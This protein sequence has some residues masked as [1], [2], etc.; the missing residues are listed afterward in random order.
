MLKIIVTLFGIEV[1]YS[2]KT[3]MSKF[4]REGCD[5]VLWSAL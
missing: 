5:S 3:L 4:L 1:K 2:V